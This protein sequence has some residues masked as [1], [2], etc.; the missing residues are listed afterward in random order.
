[1]DTHDEEVTLTEHLIHTVNRRPDRYFS[2]LVV[3]VMI[4]EDEWFLSCFFQADSWSCSCRGSHLTSVTP[5]VSTGLPAFSRSVGQ[6]C[7]R[8]VSSLCGALDPGRRVRRGVENHEPNNVIPHV[9]IPLRRHGIVSRLS[10]RKS[11]SPLGSLG[12]WRLMAPISRPPELSKKNP[13]RF[14]S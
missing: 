2:H 6:A 4:S 9:A 13:V 10:Q 14:R 3:C 1:M 12:P 8:R 5:G 11:G 7:F